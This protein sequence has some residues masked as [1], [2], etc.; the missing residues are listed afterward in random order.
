[1]LG[2]IVLLRDIYSRANDCRLLSCTM[3]VGRVPLSLALNKC[4]MD[5]LDIEPI[6]VGMVPRMYIYIQKERETM[7]MMNADRYTLSVHIYCK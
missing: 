1:M 2:G 3:L 6:V 4:R 7:M 5:K